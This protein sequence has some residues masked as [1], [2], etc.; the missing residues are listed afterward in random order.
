M[1][2]KHTEGTLQVDGEYEARL[3][4]GDRCIATAHNEDLPRANI[5]EAQANAARLARCWNTH[6]DLVNALKTIRQAI[7][8]TDADGLDRSAWMKE[9]AAAAIA[10][11][12]GGK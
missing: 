12:E 5:V 3:F 10:K 7:E 9:T 1:S 6:D 2:A 8:D 11:G 4:I